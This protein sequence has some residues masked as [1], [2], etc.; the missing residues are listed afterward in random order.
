MQDELNFEG[1][2]KQPLRTFTEKAYLDYSMYVILDRALPS[3]S[4][5]LKPVQ[6]RIIY[7]MSELGLS[8]GQKHK[9][10]ARTVGD[11]IGKFHPHGD[12]ACYEA[13]VLMAQDF[14][15]RY[16]IVDGQG[17]WGST[18]EPKS[19]AAMR[20]T[21]SKL[22]RYAEVLLSEL[23]DG[24]VDWQPNF[25][26]TLEEPAFLP[27]RLPN[28]LLN[29]TQGIAVGMSTDIP[30]HNLREIAQ[31]C[32]HLLDEPDAQ[33]RTLMKYVKGPDLPLG[34]EIITPKSDL[35]A[36]YNT[37][38]GSFKARAVYR[39]DKEAGVIIISELPYQVS[40]SKL[41]EQIAAQMRE[42]KLPMV[43]DIR[44]E[45]DH[46]ERIRVV[47][48]P[49]KRADV[50]QLMA[51]LFATTDLERN[52][53]VNIN[54]ITLEGKPKVLGLR[55]LL[56]E[57]LAF[58]TT[59]VTRRLQFRL[60]KV[61]KRLHILDG[62]LAAYL[63]LDEVIRIIRR[64]DEPKPVLMKRFKLS[65][66]Q[67]EAI[68]ETKL[69]HLA[70]LEEM[71][72]RDEQ[73]KLA[74][75]REDLE[76]FLKSKAKLKKLI[77]SEIEADAAKYGD[78]RRTKIVERE[79]AQ[80][81]D[82]SELV[83]NEPA[84][85]ILSK[86]GFVRSA[87]GHEI[88]ART[89]TYKA[90][91]EYQHAARGRSVQQ[92]VFLDSTGRA[93][94]VVAHSLPS[95]RGLGEPLSSRVD[96]PDGAKWRGVMIGEPEDLWLVASDAGYGFTVRLKETWA[97]KKAGKTLLNLP[98]G[99]LVLAPAPVPGDDALVAVTSEGGKLLLFPVKDVPELARGKGNKLFDIPSKKF[100]TREDFIT[101]MTVV[102]KD[103]SLVVR[104]GDRKMTIE[105]K[106]LKDYRGQRAQRG[107]VLPRGW[108]SVDSL[109]TE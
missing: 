26:G 92:V 51:H 46:E 38:N 14:S 68:L 36:I 103:K 39:E 25:D 48:E 102:A 105:W 6:R 7:A 89:L 62:L 84:T 4:D 59:T 76:S 91:D 32:I 47:I 56:N 100:A 9:K 87:K 73:K 33:T 49:K 80:A 88:D 86:G 94:S 18:D 27:A 8:A 65:E 10:S 44:D 75:E 106:D 61:D 30:P 74:E 28:V 58:R 5:G 66:I 22:T 95:A 57:W 45:S 34:G 78:D 85:I 83:A 107:S 67:A 52:Y 63:N 16:P 41:I 81:I 77:A 11:V 2:E 93:Y 3:L 20:Y 71:K 29:G 21:E 43:E 108:R 1:I 24:T 55:D 98:E 96:P 69:R 35:L 37:G 12:S 79:A 42:K 70:K 13:M 53:R 40:G 104:S 31:A 60:D 50:A 99:A 23:S 19:F 97:S 82:E 17:N 54:V 15:Y 64:E 101:G 72:I 90:G 109:E